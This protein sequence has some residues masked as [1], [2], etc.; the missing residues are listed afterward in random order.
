MPVFVLIELVKMPEWAWKSRLLVSK[1]PN[2]IRLTQNFRILCQFS[3]F[4][5]V[6]HR[7]FHETCVKSYKHTAFDTTFVSNSHIIADLTPKPSKNLCQK[8]LF[9]CIWHN[10]RRN[11]VNLRKKPAFDTT[12]YTTCVKAD[13]FP[14]FDTAPDRN[15]VKANDFP[16]FDTTAESITHT[17]SRF[18]KTGINSKISEL[19]IPKI[20]KKRFHAGI[21]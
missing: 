20:W 15:C 2:N 18:Q 11:C 17:V 12:A 14:A 3:F 16:T 1:S 19:Y 7:F 21:P 9:C 4:G 8:P 10:R 13:D 6:W 5:G